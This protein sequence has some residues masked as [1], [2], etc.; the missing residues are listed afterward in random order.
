MSLRTALSLPRKGQIFLFIAATE[1]FCR[2]ASSA[3]VSSS[4]VLR[5]PWFRP[6]YSCWANRPVGWAGQAAFGGTFELLVGE[7]L[8]LQ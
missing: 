5:V 2:H 1:G 8:I 3:F 6:G 7:I 4:K